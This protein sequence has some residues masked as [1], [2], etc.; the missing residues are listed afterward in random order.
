MLVQIMTFNYDP[1]CTTNGAL[2]HC[3]VVTVGHNCAMLDTST[4]VERKT[5]TRQGCPDRGVL[6]LRTRPAHWPGHKRQLRCY[7]K[8]SKTM[9]TPVCSVL[10]HHFRPAS[11]VIKAKN[12]SRDLRGRAK[13]E[14]MRTTAEFGFTFCSPA[15][16]VDH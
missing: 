16:Y 4:R 10:F 5:A 6:D 2:R 11:S 9:Q 8:R 7:F 13:Q 15:S 14:L 3:S 12:A 1:S